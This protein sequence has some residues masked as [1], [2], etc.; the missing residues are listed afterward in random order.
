MKKVIVSII[1]LF[2]FTE[3]LF[4]GTVDDYGQSCLDGDV[5]RCYQLGMMYRDGVG[6]EKN[7]QEAKDFFEIACDL[8]SK[9]ACF[10]LKN[11]SID[12]SKNIQSEY[13]NVRFGFSFVYPDDLFVT[14][15]LSDNGDG[16]TLYNSDKSLELRAYGSWYGD[17]INQV[18]RDELKW[19]KESA[20]KVS[21]KV[22][23]KQWFVLSGTDREKQKIFYQKTFFKE[24]K[25][26]SF[27][28]EY[29][30]KDK[31]KYNALVSLI[32]KS[33]RAQ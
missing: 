4:S 16:V 15:I 14:K 27:R 13:T 10:E 33:F 8:G 26:T 5:E 17:T 32:N 28:M 12:R 3:M 6:I 11:K 23:K 30:I 7:A 21:Y 25:S 24:G 2:G 22:L 20:K 29:P 31:A 19:A 1:V 9:Q 18:Y